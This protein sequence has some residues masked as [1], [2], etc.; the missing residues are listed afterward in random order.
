MKTDYQM[1]GKLYPKIHIHLKGGQWKWFYAC[2]TNQ[3]KTCRNAKAVF[4]NKN[5]QYAPHV[6]RANFAED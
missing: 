4:L 3:S 5:P 2:S 6:V 1:T